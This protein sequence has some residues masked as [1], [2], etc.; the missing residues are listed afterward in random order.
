MRSLAGVAALLLLAVLAKL[1]HAHVGAVPLP[2]FTLGF[3]MSVGGLLR[4]HPRG[5]AWQPPL[6]LPL[7]VG[8]ILLGVQFD[9]SRCSRGNRTLT[10]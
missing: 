10:G 3:S 4:R 8:M 1:V 7:S 9:A 5:A 2:L 6:A